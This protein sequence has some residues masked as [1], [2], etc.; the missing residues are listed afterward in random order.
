MIGKLLV[1]FLCSAVYSDVY[2]HNPRGSNNRLDESGRERDNAN[3]MFDSQNNNRGGY[4]VGNLY[5]IE[6]SQLT[7]E[8]TNQHSCGEKN[9]NCEIVLQYMCSDNLRDGDRTSTI[10]ENQG[11][12]TNMDCNSDLRYGMNEDYDHYMNCIYTS[13]NKGLF[14]ADQ[15]LAGVSARYTRQNPQGTRRGYECPEERDYYPY[16]RPT[17]WKDIAVMTNDVSQCT[18]YQQESENVKSRFVCVPPAGY[19]D[20]LI[21]N[22]VGGN[23]ANNY[24]GITQ[25]ACEKLEW[26]KNS[27]N[28]ANWTEIPSRNLNPP[29][30]V[31]S[32]RSRD[33]HNGNGLGGFPTTYN[34]TIPSDINENCV[35]RLRYNIS[36]GDY[37][38][39]ANSSNNNN[40]NKIKVGPLVGLSDTEATN[41]GY[42]FNNNPVVQPLKTTNAN[43]GSRLQLRLAINTAQYGRTFQ[44]RSHRFA[45]RSRPADFNGLKMYNLNVRGKRGNIVQ[46]YPAVEYDFVPNRLT[47]SA[48]DAIHIQWTGS[49]SNPNNNEGQGR[50]GSDRSNI[51]LLTDLPYPKGNIRQDASIENKKGQY[52]NN[53]PTSLTLPNRNLLGLNVADIKSLAILNPGQYG[54]K[55]SELDDAGTYFDLGPRKLTS[56]G[57]GTY[58]YMCTRNNNFSNRSQKGKLVVKTGRIFMAQIGFSGGTVTIDNNQQGV[59]IPPGRLES[60][61]QISVEEWS[62]DDGH[63][64]I[65][66]Y[67]GYVNV[68]N[69]DGSNFLQVTPFGQLANGA[70]VT[71][72]MKVFSSDVTIYRSE[73]F[74]NWQNIPVTSLSST[75]AQFQTSKGGV[76]I[77]RKNKDYKTRNIIIGVVVC[78][79][80]LA[81]LVVGSFLYFK[82]HPNA[83]PGFRKLGFGFKSKV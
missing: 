5:Y 14:T 33:N 17:P 26:P 72:K 61:I 45:I 31:S 62:T 70:E 64:I 50:A 76:Y 52:G 7:I 66:S 71:M 48:S 47:L 58:Y 12:C 56:N 69:T 78:F 55:M 44:D 23:P 22:K 63:K 36:T 75:L 83:F 74:V 37:P 41:R 13:R 1:T 79:V 59:W 29:E 16:W 38:L 77:A 42:L 53:I 30:C 6:G 68:G 49:N 24:L 40:A 20:A 25:E 32:P 65:N 10:P 15:N 73:N 2:L 19:M 67:G 4:N 27:G 43:L 3:R 21:L 39:D 54:G 34:W 28:K 82:K 11:K 51:L 18:R 60:A 8:W 80:I 35:L 46:V 57:N 81:I 9:S